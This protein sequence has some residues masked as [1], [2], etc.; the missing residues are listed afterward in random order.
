MQEKITTNQEETPT[1]QAPA[2][3]LVKPFP[4]KKSQG[5]FAKTAVVVVMI[6]IAGVATGYV[7]SS[8]QGKFR[9]LRSTESISETGLSA[10]DVFG[11]PDEETFR[12]KAEGVLVKGGIDGEGSHHLARP[13]GESQDVYLTS[14]VVDLDKFVD[15]KVKVWGETFEAQKAGW[16]MDVGRVEVLEL[17]AE[18]PSE[19]N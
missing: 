13:G 6:M 19:N 14:S 3:Q 11:N 4:M 2:D 1:P 10:G 18:K 7:L 15:H 9:S 12:D 17:N 8:G 5:P 16:L